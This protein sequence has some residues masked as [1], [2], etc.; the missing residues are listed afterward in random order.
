MFLDIGSE[1][2]RSVLL[3]S[4]AS[5]A[6]EANKPQIALQLI[7]LGLSGCPPPE[8]LDELNALRSDVSNSTS[9]DQHAAPSSRDTVHSDST[10]LTQL[11][12]LSKTIPCAASPRR[13]S[14][15]ARALKSIGI[16]GG[17]AAA[18][19]LSLF[20]LSAVIPQG[21]FWSILAKLGPP[22][23]I[24]DIVTVIF[25]ATA[26][27]STAVLY[28]RAARSSLGKAMHERKKMI[29]ARYKRKLAKKLRPRRRR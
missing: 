5:L 10:K 28:S 20:S 17:L 1:P 4:A 15:L 11:D 12:E 7:D 23:S 3:R 6:I 9:H 13:T 19:V 27:G 21:F 24:L 14:R 8:I 16:S 26:F 25:T 18:L 22:Y 2:T 29:S